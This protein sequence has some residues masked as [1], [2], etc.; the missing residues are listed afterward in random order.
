MENCRTNEVLAEQIAVLRE[1]VAK[2]D[3][4][5]LAQLKVNLAVIENATNTLKGLV[6]YLPE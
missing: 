2:L 1:F 6:E 3:P 4:I 5:D